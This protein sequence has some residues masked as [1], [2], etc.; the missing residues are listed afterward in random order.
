LKDIYVRVNAIN[1]VDR[2]SAPDEK[3][4]QGEI[5]KRVRIAYDIIDHVLGKGKK[6]SGT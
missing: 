4:P 6:M 2:P 3:L 1:E 5:K